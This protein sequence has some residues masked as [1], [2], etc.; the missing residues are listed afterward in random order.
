MQGAFSCSLKRADFVAIVIA[1]WWR[2]FVE[3]RWSAL[4]LAAFL[5]AGLVFHIWMLILMSGLGLIFFFVVKPLRYVGGALKRYRTFRRWGG[6]LTIEVRFSDEGLAFAQSEG[7]VPSPTTRW[8]FFSGLTESRGVLLL[9]DAR[10]VPVLGLPL[11][12][13]PSA[14][15]KRTFVET[16]ARGI[17]A[18]S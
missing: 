17:S 1:I 6:S 11:R 5:A 7:D 3:A 2:E 16:A 4:A 8:K 15:M 9:H 10:G 13:F 14:D 18:A 12:L